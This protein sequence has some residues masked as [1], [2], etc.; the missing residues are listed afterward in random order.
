MNDMLTPAAVIEENEK[1]DSDTLETIIGNIDDDAKGS[2]ETIL[3][4][5]QELVK[6]PYNGVVPSTAVGLTAVGLAEEVSVPLM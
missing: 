5:C 3:N 6:A 1:E 4:L 2:A